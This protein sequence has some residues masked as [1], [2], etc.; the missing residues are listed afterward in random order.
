MNVKKSRNND[1][2]QAWPENPM[3][4]Q[5]IMAAMSDICV[6]RGWKYISLGDDFDLDIDKA[7]PGVNTTDAKEVTIAFLKCV[8]HYVQGLEF[9]KIPDGNDKAKRLRKLLNYNL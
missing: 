4:N 3:K 7:V 6:E 5:L 1:F 9:L 2:R 8:K